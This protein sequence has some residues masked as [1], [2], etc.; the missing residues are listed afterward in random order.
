MKV[1]NKLKI[2]TK[3]ILLIT[4]MVGCT[5]VI[6]AV[7]YNYTNKSHIALANIYDQNL[8][9]I[10]LL[11]DVR[12]QARANYA[13][14]LKL[15]VVSDS[16]AQDETKKDI[17]A[18]IEK[19]K[20][21]LDEYSKQNLDSKEKEQY[22]IIQKKLEE[23]YS[24]FNNI[25]DL[26]DSGKTREAVNVFQESGN[27]IF[28]E[29]QTCIRDLADYTM[30][31]AETTYQKNSAAD[32]EAILFLA[33][34]IVSVTIISI[35]FGVLIIV[36][37]TKPL[38]KLV[39][40]I[41]KTSNLDLVYD[42]SFEKLMNYKG[43]VGIMVN[44]VLEMRNALRNMADN[45]IAVSNNLAD[46]SKDLADS[47]DESSKTI[48][49]VVNAIN[50]IAEG[51]NSQAEI[52]TKASAALKDVTNSIDEVNKDTLINAKNAESS[53]EIVKEGQKAVDI[54][55]LKMQDNISVTGDVGES[56]R[57]LSDLMLEVNSI[58]GL[59]NEIASQ[60]NLL[61]LNAAIE[62]ARAGEAG[63]GFAVVAEEIR[64][65]A[66]GSTSAAKEISDIIDS[67]VTKN[68]IAEEN[69][70]KVKEIVTEQEEAARITKEVFDK[71]KTSVQDI[72]DKT[73]NS[74][75][76]I[77]KIDKA[78]RE[79]SAKT[80]DMAAVA[81]ESAASSEEI[82]ASSEEQLASMEEISKAADRL[83]DMAVELKM[84]INKFK[85]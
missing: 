29:L 45:I 11:S 49:Q 30:K 40:F 47:T 80:Q 68:K 2:R 17:D 5:F 76:V 14:A 55:I 66:E 34:L 77:N 84:E 74:S 60:T 18:R 59:I 79:I 70:D 28:E 78:S 57:E 8:V 39:V 9:S 43:E 72:A 6:G 73:K 21:D 38:N 42:N 64:K 4:F 85:I 58:T 53:L 22:E 23:W 27:D 67:T 56:I 71:I 10:E 20:N 46:N 82:S 1:L 16:A 15:M 13:N 50:E 63:K 44:S 54:T 62:A 3:L 33:I 37:I 52:I 12:T 36:S 51:N 81:E 24:I 65:L 25:R 7:G 61:A 26:T 48:N 41:K 83:S 69:M 35:L 19:L 32:R 31:E 75:A